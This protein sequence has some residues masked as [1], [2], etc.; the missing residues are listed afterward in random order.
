MQEPTFLRIIEKHFRHP[1]ADYGF[2]VVSESKQAELYNHSIVFARG[3]CGIN[4]VVERGDVDILVA[5]AET[6][7]DWANGLPDYWV[8]LYLVI[9]FVAA[10]M[11]VEEMAHL[12]PTTDSK[13]PRIQMIE[14]QM[15]D[16]A[17]KAAPFWAK[18]IEFCGAGEIVRF[19]TDLEQ[20]QKAINQVV[21][22]EIEKKLSAERKNAGASRD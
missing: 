1:L 11:T 16:W 18:V 2:S 4:F 22:R 9:G 17:R 20:L 3:R 21:M 5:A 14:E 12:H 7:D 10:D 13:G 19:K 15:K 8:P 6:A